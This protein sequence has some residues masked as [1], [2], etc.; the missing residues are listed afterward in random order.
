[1]MRTLGLL[2][3]ILGVGISAT[4]GSILAP[5]EHTRAVE[6]GRQALSDGPAP[7][8]VTA[9]PAE[10]LTSW[11]GLAGLPFFGGL[12]LVVAGASMSRVAA[13]S[14]LKEGGSPT[15]DGK[16]VDFGA[17]LGELGADTAR[18]ADEMKA[19]TAPEVTTFEAMQKKVE[20]LQ[21]EKVERLVAAGPVLQ[22]RYG[23]DSF[24]AVFSPMSGGERK[25]NR[26]WSALVD[27]HWPEATRSMTDAAEAFKDAGEE[28]GRRSPIA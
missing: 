24:A 5:A 28:L 15:S 14:A 9:G 17:L 12:V 20:E 10:R 13:K 16:A 23:L 2:L 7:A 8:E 4:F 27:Q 22:L 25:L 6:E 1:M 21:R 18:L 11:A 3:V 26:T 19:Q